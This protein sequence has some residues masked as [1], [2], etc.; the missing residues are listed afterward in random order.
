MKALRILTRIGIVLL[1]V[2]AAVLV[3]RAILN[4]T[5]GRALTKALAALKARGIPLAA[6]DLAPPCPDEDNAARL[7]KAVENIS[8]IP[9]RKTSNPG[10]PPH[11]N[12]ASDIGGLISRAWNDFTAGRPITPADRAALKDVILKNEKAFALLA[13][14]GN[15]PC[16]LYRDPAES[17]VESRVPDAIQMIKTTELLFF[18]SLFSIEDGD[19]PSAVTKLLT[20]LKF[21]PLAA[22]EGTLIAYLISVA[23][24][25]FLSQSLG[26]ICRGREVA[27]EDLVG[28]MAALNPSLWPDRLAAAWRGERVMFVEVGEY[29]IKGSLADLGSIWEGPTWWQKLGLWILRPL[30]KRDLRRSLPRFEWLEAQARL[31]YYRNREALRSRDRDI[32]EGLPWHAFLSRMT[33]PSGVESVFMKSAQIEAIMLASRAGLACRLYKIRTGQY[34]ESLESLVPALLPEV[35][36][37]PFT[38]K[39]MVYRRDGKGFIV[40][41]LGSNQKDDGGRS[42]YA[43]T[44]LVMEKDDDWRWRE[45]R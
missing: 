10:Q 42:T 3:L 19:V 20:G 14:M 16:F 43:I 30:V 32:Q 41:S 17:L 28:L 25:R 33:A 27:E 29:L 34:P 4:F 26:E 11:K 45:D 5:E 44:Q 24:S 6:R 38:G 40:Y 22:G 39:P 31:P 2:V 12:G 1:I 21:T 35:P 37:D 15:K 9:G 7:W 18:S 23:E 13:E 8:A 36:T